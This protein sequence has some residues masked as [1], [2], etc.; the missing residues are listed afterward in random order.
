MKHDLLSRIISM[1]KTLAQVL[2]LRYFSSIG[3]VCVCVCLCMCL[4]KN[5]VRNNLS[6]NINFRRAFLPSTFA[7]EFFS[8][9]RL[10]GLWKS[11]KRVL[12]VNGSYKASV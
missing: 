1:I 9:K 8:T 7:L 3:F 6:L 12:C 2:L 4:C 11:V 5:Q 10:L